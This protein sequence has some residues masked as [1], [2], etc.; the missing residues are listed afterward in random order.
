MTHDTGTLP[1][2]DLPPV[3]PDAPAPRWVAHERAQPVHPAT[4]DRSGSLPRRPAQVASLLEG[5]R[6]R[7][8]ER[9]SDG[10]VTSVVTGR[11][12]ARRRSHEWSDRRRAVVALLVMGA[13]LAVAAWGAFAGRSAVV[14]GLRA[15]VGGAP[16]VLDGSDGRA[17]SADAAGGAVGDAAGD[18]AGTAR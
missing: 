12:L 7:V 3:A 8:R 1:R 5:L 4:G 13:L 18:A 10:V 6:G 9:A 14:P 16:V 2:V 11:D 15:V 17:P